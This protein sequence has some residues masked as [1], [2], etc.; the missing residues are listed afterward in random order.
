MCQSVLLQFYMI[1][2]LEREPHWQPAT[3]GTARAGPQLAALTAPLH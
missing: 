1:L 3:T 2:E